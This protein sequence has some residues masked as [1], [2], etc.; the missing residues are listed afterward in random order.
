MVKAY[1]K[2]LMQNREYELPDKPRVK[3]GRDSESNDVFIMNRIM[4]HIQKNGEIKDAYVRVSREHCVIYQDKPEKGEF[5]IEDNQSTKGTFVNGKDIGVG[6][7]S[8][9]KNGD[10]ITLGRYKLEFR[11]DGEKDK[12]G[13]ENNEK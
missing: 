6:E 7:S 13:G 5:M 1:L 11:I 8:I 12:S 3:L 9:L 10:K 4:D 2:D